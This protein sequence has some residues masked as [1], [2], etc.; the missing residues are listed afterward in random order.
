MLNLNSD[1]TF[2][3]RADLRPASFD[4]QANT[5]EAVISTGAGVKRRDSQGIYT[6]ILSLEPA[7]IDMSRLAGAPVLDS[8]SQDSA[9]DVIGVIQSARIEGGTLMATIRLSA[10]P[11]V[12]ATVLKIREGVL[13]AV[14]VGYSVSAWSSSTSSGDRVKTATRW[15]PFEASVVAVAADPGAKFRNKT[16]ESRSTTM[17]NE[18][19]IIERP[20]TDEV[21]AN[22]AAIREIARSAGLGSAWADS[23][24]DEG[25]DVTATRAAAFEVMQKRSQPGIR[26]QQIGPSGDDPTIIRERRADALFA[27]V[28]GTAPKD[29]AKPYVNDRLADHARGI[30]T[31]RGEATR[32]MREEEILTRAAQHAMSD[33]PSLLTGTGQRILMAGYQAAPNV[34][35]SLARKGTRTDFRAGTSLRLGEIGKLDRLT[36]S[37][38]VKSKSRAEA[39][40]SYGLDTFAGMFSLS[41]KAIVNDDLGA[42]RDW[43]NAAG[44]A[45]AET[46]A[47]QLMDLL[48]QSAGLGPLM[49]DGKRLF[50]VDHG[51]LAGAGATPKGVGD[52]APLTAGRLAMRNQKGLDGKTPINAAPKF[53]LVPA[54]LETESEQI[55]SALYAANVADVNPFSSKLTPLVDARLSGNGWYLFADP[56]IL[57]VLEYAYLS[58]AEGPQLASREG[59][60]VLGQEFRVVLDFGCGVVDWRGAFRNPGA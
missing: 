32:G 12:A 14:S 37:G 11:D 21:K 26:T 38:E 49:G 48:T 23:R 59:W 46:E 25:A 19:T 51:N 13:R 43:G 60:D 9:R 45:A 50:H 27:R 6:E 52:L 58:G 39:K 54:S 7:H 36:E 34:L 22:R 53:M 57:P 42:F 10:A 30:L 55:A 24:I 47:G 3:R 2:T 33:F 5:I 8:H 44:Q 1:S 17:E 16:T 41:R 28:M 56:A 40:E 18:E 4:E 29:E 35:K 15:T 31:M 20:P